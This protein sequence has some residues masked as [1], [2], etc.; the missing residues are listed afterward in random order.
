M[1]L[2]NWL[3]L[4]RTPWVPSHSTKTISLLLRGK[5]VHTQEGVVKMLKL[6]SLIFMVSECL[7]LLNSQPCWTAF[8]ILVTQHKAC[9]CST[10]TP[11]FWA[12]VT[13]CCVTSVPVLGNP[14]AP[15]YSFSILG[16]LTVTVEHWRAF[17][18]PPLQN[19][20]K[21][22]LSFIKLKASTAEIKAHLG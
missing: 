17:R 10:L 13:K 18:K 6:Y 16:P 12:F 8:H 1:R 2:L 4:P 15:I 11:P 3:T 9:H 5:E 22:K 14:W 20:S 19:H 7:D 21:K